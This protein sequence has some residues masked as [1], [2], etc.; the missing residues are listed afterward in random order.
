MRPFRRR[1]KKLIV[2]FH[3]QF[4][5]PTAWKCDACRRSGLELKRRCGWIPAAQQTTPHVVW[6]R[7]QVSTD[8]CP[9]SL[10]TGESISFIE[11]FLARKRLGL[12]VTEEISARKAEAFL[13][14]EEQWELEG[15]SGAK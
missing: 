15:L 4:S 9:K 12:A 6:A 13:S 11:D 8:V 7:K 5:N 3:F 10:I 2:A 1:T 14:L